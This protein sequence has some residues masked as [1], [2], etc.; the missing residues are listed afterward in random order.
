MAKKSKKT[1]ANEVSVTIATE[2][3]CDYIKDVKKASLHTMGD[4]RIAR[5]SDYINALVD[6]WMD[7]KK[8]PNLYNFAYEWIS[9]DYSVVVGMGATVKYLVGVPDSEC[10][11]VV[12]EY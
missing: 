7:L 10:K 4:G 3:V 8:K 1:R 11:S 2:A 9:K 6:I 12:F 5:I